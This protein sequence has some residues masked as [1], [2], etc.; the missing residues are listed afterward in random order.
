M[1]RTRA[2]KRRLAQAALQRC[3]RKALHAA[4]R[5][6]R[7]QERLARAWLVAAVALLLFAASLGIDRLLKVAFVIDR[8]VMQ[9]VW[10][11]ILAGLLWGVHARPLPEAHSIPLALALA[12]ALRLLWHAFQPQAVIAPLTTLV[13]IWLL[14]A[15]L[16]EGARRVAQSRASAALLRGVRDLAVLLFASEAVAITN[17]I[18]LAIADHALLEAGAA[19]ASWLIALHTALRLQML[20]PVSLPCRLMPIVFGLAAAHE[21]FRLF[22]GD[23]EPMRNALDVGLLPLWNALLLGYL[24]PGL[25]LARMA[26]E[27]APSRLRL[28]LA[29]ASL[30]FGLAWLFYETRHAFR[31]AILSAPLGEAERL[32]ILMLWLGFACVCLLA[33]W[34]RAN[35]TFWLVAVATVAVAAVRALLWDWPALSSHARATALAALCIMLLVVILAS[36]KRPNAGFW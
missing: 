7:L 14:P 9:A 32:V 30:P 31:G 33:A 4:G 27:L 36:R 18:A 15:L 8:T 16:L 24:L 3:L 25:L 17:G 5:W 1:T 35:A 20:G 6:A 26:Q 10:A 13:P 19:L 28:G 34:I 12:L 22:W 2:R 29:A 11:N 23:A 21:A